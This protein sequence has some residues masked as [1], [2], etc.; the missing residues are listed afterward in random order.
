MNM[1]FPREKTV[2]PTTFKGTINLDTIRAASVFGK[3]K[4]GS[5]IAAAPVNMQSKGKL[6][7][8]ALG[9]HSY[10]LVIVRWPGVGM[11][12]E[13]EPSV[14]SQSRYSR[15]ESESESESQNTSTPQPCLECLRLGVK[16]TKF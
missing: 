12:S 10:R 16:Q 11:E 4:N 8:W 2:M 3:L 9:N 15:S 5:W 7:K 14:V 13:S 1:P 6:I